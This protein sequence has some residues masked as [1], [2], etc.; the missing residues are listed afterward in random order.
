MRLRRRNCD[1]RCVLD[2]IAG[3]ARADARKGDA[4]GSLRLRDLQRAGVAGG[5]QLGLAERAAPDRPHSVDD[6]ARRQQVA[7][8]QLGV[9]GFAAAEKSTLMNKVRSGGA[10]NGAIHPAAAQERRIGGVD[11][12]VDVERGDIGLNGESRCSSQ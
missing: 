12:G 7:L 6:E 9:A 3:N 4:S 5:E 1:L 8:G 11:D 10:M 2:G